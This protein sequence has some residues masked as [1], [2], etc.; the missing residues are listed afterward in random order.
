MYNDENSRLEK[1]KKIENNVIEEVT[2]AFRLK[3]E[4]DGTTVKNIKIFFR[5]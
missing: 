1:N 3:K 4:I 5:L 2:N